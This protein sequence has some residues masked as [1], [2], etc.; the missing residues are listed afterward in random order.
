MSTQTNYE[1]DAQDYESYAMHAIAACGGSTNQLYAK[2]YLAARM[3]GASPEDATGMATEVERGS[4][5]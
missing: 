2:V 5:S 4:L 3:Y 1:L